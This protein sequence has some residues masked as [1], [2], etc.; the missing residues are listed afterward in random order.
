[1]TND[2]THDWPADSRPE[3][4]CPSLRSPLAVLRRPFSLAGRTDV[5]QTATLDIIHRVVGTGTAW[6]GK[7]NPDDPVDLIGPLGNAFRLPPPGHTALLVGG[8]VGLPPMLYLAQALRQRDC[9]AIAF[10]GATTADLLPVRID[11]AMPPSTD[12]QPNRAVRDFAIHG[13]NTI[14]TTDDGTIGLKGRITDG[15][16]AFLAGSPDLNTKHATLYTCGPEPMMKAA[17]TIAAQHRIPC[18]V[19]VEQAMACGMGTCQ[20]CV[21]KIH[22]ADHPHDHTP[23]GRPWR[24]RLTCTDGPIFDAAQLLW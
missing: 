10:V 24:F 9:N 16:T 19:C 17:A 7:L 22:D 5:G 23:D 11:R 20:S 14:V 18:Q 15:L 8:G 13:Y 21:V 2:T 3:I 4:S 6:L 1:M 12:A